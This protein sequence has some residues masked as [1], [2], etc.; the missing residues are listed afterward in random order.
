MLSIARVVRREGGSTY[1]GSCVD[2]PQPV[3][4]ATTSTLDATSIRMIAS[5][6]SAMGNACI[7]IREVLRGGD[8]WLHL[9][10]RANVHSF[11]QPLPLVEVL[12]KL[13]CI[14]RHAKNCS[15]FGCWF[16]LGNDFK[17]D[18]EFGVI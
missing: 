2:L 9:L 3:S 13:Q 1:C 15:V 4:P 12:E 16:S 10:R 6:L 8:G 17:I 14:L 18:A 5:R 11:L 7:R